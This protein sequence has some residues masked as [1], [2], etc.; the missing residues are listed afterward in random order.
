MRGI[1]FFRWIGWRAVTLGEL[2]TP[3]CRRSAPALLVEL[4]SPT[5]ATAIIDASAGTS[6]PYIVIATPLSCTHVR[7]KVVAKA[8]GAHLCKSSAIKTTCTST[9]CALAGFVPGHL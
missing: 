9:T 1:A 4:T 7:G 6:A 2:F 3:T 5:T 8:L